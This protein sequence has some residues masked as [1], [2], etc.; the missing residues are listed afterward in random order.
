[1][2]KNSRKEISL[3]FLFIASFTCQ[4]IA[5]AVSI[6]VPIY[7]ESLKAPILLVG[8]IGSAGGLV[9]SFLP[10][11]AGILCDRIRRKIFIFAS[12]TLYGCACLLYNYTEEASMLVFA[13]V[14]EWSSVAIFWPAVEALLADSSGLRLEETLRRFNLSW[15]SAMVIGPVIGGSLITV[16]SIKAPFIFSM[17]LSTIFGITSLLILE[18]PARKHEPKI[19]ARAEPKD[20]A[21]EQYPLAPGL[22]SIFLFSSVIGIILTIFPAYA[23]K[24][25]ISAFN[26]GWIVF[27]FG[28]ARV[29]T[30]SQSNRLETK[31][32]KTGMFLLGSSFLGASSLLTALSYTFPLYVLCFALF[33][34]GAGLSY[35][36]SIALVL[37]RWESSRGR[38]AGV[39]ES[40]IGFGYF[41]GPLIGGV[42]SEYS[43]VA[44]YYYGFILSVAVFIVQLFSRRRNSAN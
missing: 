26:I 34:I 23:S 16:W 37:R 9:Y 36:A 43:E 15:G 25:E 7:A 39:F 29:I 3:T 44:P 12:L 31:I 13:K 32:G 40:L 2:G 22:A 24:L 17:F 30:F 1:V 14:L 27:A 8:I 38:A 28:A 11:I 20:T 6:T 10:F 33:G 35:A 41:V 21:N 5:G 19:H 4:M 42:V 18:E